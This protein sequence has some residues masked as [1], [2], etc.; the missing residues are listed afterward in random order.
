MK[1]GKIIG[2]KSKTIFDFYA[3]ETRFPIFAREGLGKLS[4]NSKKISVANETMQNV[5]ASMIYFD[6]FFL[7][8]KY[9]YATATT[10]QLLL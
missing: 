5:L 1:S 7:S 3:G 8:Q 2:K 6:G 10:V 4:H 9:Q